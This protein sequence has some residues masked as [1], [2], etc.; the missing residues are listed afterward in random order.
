MKGPKNVWGAMAPPG[1]PLET[2]LFAGDMK[3]TKYCYGYPI[4]CKR[5][6]YPTEILP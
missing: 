4:E 1:P 3:G 5:S 2:P 6:P